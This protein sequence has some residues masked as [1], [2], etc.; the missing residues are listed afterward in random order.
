MT[1]KK[2]EPRDDDKQFVITTISRSEVREMCGDDDADRLSDED[3]ERL[4]QEMAETYV[5]GSFVDDLQE[6]IED[7]F[8]ESSEDEED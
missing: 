5:S 2:A 6:I 7:K 1:K 3:M 4:A 8:S